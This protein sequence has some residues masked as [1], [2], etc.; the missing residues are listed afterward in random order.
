MRIQKLVA[1]CCVLVLLLSCSQ[2]EQGAAPVDERSPV[3]Q[4]SAPSPSV[5]FPVGTVLLEDAEDDDDPVLLTVEVAETPEQ[6]QLGLMFR[7]SLPDERGMVFVFFEDISSGFYM[8]N[9]L[10]PL[11]IAFFDI[12]GKILRIMDMEPCEKDPCKVYNPGVAYR[13]ALEVNQGA[14]ERWD[15]SEGDFVRLTR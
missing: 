6:Y 7:E 14:F 11:S 9:T 8:K 4:K 2:P 5:E 10:I 13:G 1:G 12:N 3:V 15:I